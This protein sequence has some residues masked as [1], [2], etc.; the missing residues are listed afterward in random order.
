M[1]SD[2]NHFDHLVFCSD[3][4]FDSSIEELSARD[5]ISLVASLQNE[6]FNEQRRFD[7]ISKKISSFVGNDA[8][9][10]DLLSTKLCISQAKLAQLCARNMK[11]FTQQSIKSQSQRQCSN[12][13]MRKKSFKDENVCGNSQSNQPEDWLSPKGDGETRKS[14]LSEG[15][16]S[17]DE[18]ESWEGQRHDSDWSHKFVEESNRIEHEYNSI[19]DGKIAY[20][21]KKEAKVPTVEEIIQ[22]VKNLRMIK[23]END[24]QSS[25]SIEEVDSHIYEQIEPIYNNVPGGNSIYANI[26]N[27]PLYD[28]PRSLSNKG[29]ILQRSQDVLIPTASQLILQA[30]TAVSSDSE[31]S[32]CDRDSLENGETAR[33]P[34]EIPS[35]DYGSDE[36]D[37]AYGVYNT[38]D[39]RPVEAP[40]FIED[41][42]L[43]VIVE[44]E[45]EGDDAEDEDEDYESRS[46]RTLSQDSPPLCP[47]NS[48]EGYQHSESDEDQSF[49]YTSP[50][51]VES[52]G[53]KIDLPDSA[54]DVDDISSL[55]GSTILASPNGEEEKRERS[56]SPPQTA[57]FE[58]SK[59]V[60]STPRTSCTSVLNQNHDSGMGDSYQYHMK[61]EDSKWE[62]V[63]PTKGNANKIAGPDV[64]EKETLLPSVKA[65]RS[66]F[67]KPSTTAAT[68]PRNFQ[69][70]ERIPEVD[71]RHS[72]TKFGAGQIRRS[73]SVVA[74]RDQT[75]PELLDTLNLSNS[76]SDCYISNTLPT[77]FRNSWSNGS[78][79]TV[80][81]RTAKPIFSLDQPPD[82]PIPSI[83]AQFGNT[84]RVHLQSSTLSQWDPTLLLEELYQVQSPQPVHEAETA[85][86]MNIE[87]YLDKLPSGRRKATFWNAWKRRYFR[88]K[89]GYLYYYQNHS[90]EKPSLILNLMGGHI[91]SMDTT[92]LG[93][94]DGSSLFSHN[95]LFLFL[96]YQINYNLFLILKGHYVVVRCSSKNEVEHWKTALNTHIVEKFNLTYAQP[97]PAYPQFY[98]DVLIIDLGSSSVRAGI[99]CNQPTLPQIFFP[100]VSSIDRETAH[101]IYGAEALSPTHKT[102]GSVNFPLRPSTKITRFSVDFNA[103]VGLLTKVFTDLNV[104]PTEFQ[105]QL[106]LPRTFTVQTQTEVLRILF[107]DFRVRSV[108]LTSQ[109]VLSLLSYNTSSGIVVDVGERLDVIPIIDGYIVEAGVSRIPYGGVHVMDHLQHFLIQ[110]HYNLVSE[111]DSYLV[112]Y[113]LENLCYCAENYHDELQKFFDNP[114]SFESICELKFLS[115]DI[116]WNEIVLDNGR[117][118]AC[119]GLFNPDAWGLDHPG[120]H[121]LV[122]RAIQ[123]CSVDIRK[124]MTRSIYLSG[125]L[126]LLPGFLSRLESEVNNLTPP[127][128]VPKVHA[129]P[130]RYHSA[131]LGAC[132]LA[133]SPSF[134]EAK[135]SYDDWKQNGAQSLRKWHL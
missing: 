17:K 80:G 14:N 108:N 54:V 91:D 58:T 60:F 53:A 23:Q 124:E 18:C 12:S 135:I 127:S 88:L 28:I 97:V 5:M 90:S 19:D 100:T 21:L 93:M 83:I 111:V 59:I 39:E 64:S 30:Q 131:Y 75:I 94:D 4:D 125:G 104:D 55:D 34:P 62:Y 33:N 116:P 48:D 40:Y 67:E 76:K 102:S 110:R 112:R 36:E 44:E 47:K 114:E 118:Q 3:E 1:E 50:K 35:P 52:G 87:G 122:H 117:F 106:S 119:E 84:D 13:I 43:E 130:Y 109:T 41:Q 89:D 133:S 24:R 79:G 81:P 25:S 115:S 113:V 32:D 69:V 37:A 29:V 49:K 20:E 9:E 96:F 26:T 16:H 63:G 65:L 38:Y 126:T 57:K 31:A 46:D 82:R 56:W 70:K 129:S 120:V 68:F 103:V 77:K 101:R 66:Q 132:I 42:G 105:I 99:L 128:L 22:S 11:C 2:V 73:K 134:Q 98:E 61:L 15:L 85:C 71:S 121:K 95:I 45:E 107:D 10:N 72:S 86:F 123:E 7:E 92:M 6:M 78:N 74:E 8:K 27:E 51:D